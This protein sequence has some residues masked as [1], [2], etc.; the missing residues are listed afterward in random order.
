MRTE[1][2]LDKILIKKN[3]RFNVHSQRLQ[4]IKKYAAQVC[5]PI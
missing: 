4:Y 3:C 2:F 5:I 1:L